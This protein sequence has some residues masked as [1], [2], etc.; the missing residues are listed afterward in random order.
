MGALH[1][2]WSAKGRRRPYNKALTSRRHH[3]KGSPRQRRW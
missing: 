1:V 2:P 3:S